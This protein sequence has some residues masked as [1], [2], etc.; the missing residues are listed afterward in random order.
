M[1]DAKN[2][3]SINTAE[4][5]SGLRPILKAL[6]DDLVE[7]A[8]LPGVR[9][10]LRKAYAKEK[11]ASRTADP[12]DL[13]CRWRATQ[14]AASWV[15]SIIFVRTLEDR[16]LIERRRIAGS[17]AEDS[18]QQLRA[19]APFLSDRDY[20]LTVFR[21][22]SRL[23]GVADIFDARH[24]PVWILGPSGQMAGRLL[25]FFREKN[26]DGELR[27]QFGGPDTRFLG[28]LYQDLDEDVRKKFA[29]LQTPDFVESFILD[30]T[31]TPAI[32]TFGLAETKIIDPTCGSGHFLLG[33]FGRLC[34]AWQ[35][36]EPA[37]DKQVLA[38]RALAQVHG[39]DLNPYAVAIARFRLTLA[40]MDAAGIA[41]V[42]KAPPLPLNVCVADSLLHGVT[43]EELRF[44]DQANSGG[45]QAWGDEM[46]ALEDEAEALR[47]LKQRYQAVVGNPPYITEQDRAKRELYRKLYKDSAS[48]KFALGAPFTE[49]FFTL[50]TRGGYAGMI[51][52][53]AFLKRE[54]GKKLIE[55]FLPRVELDLV[56]DTSGAYIPG[57]GTP[58]VLLFGRNQSAGATNIQAVLGSRGEP[59]TPADASKGQVWSSIRDHYNEVGFENDYITVAE[60]ERKRLAKHPWIMAGG[61]AIELMDTLDLRGERPLGDWATSIGFMAITG[62]DD[63]FLRS[64][65]YLAHR[66][67]PTRI[68]GIGEVVRDWSVAEREYLI[69]PYDGESWAP[70]DISKNAG[71]ERELWP[72]KRKL[73]T[74]LMF[75]KTQIQAGFPW[76]EYRH[77]GREKLRT[78]LSIAFAFVA[79]HNH[80]VLDRGGKVFKQTAP[81]IKLPDH[82]TEDDHLALLGYLNSST[83]CFWMKQVCQPKHM[84][85][86]SGANA[87]PFLVRF[88]FD[89]TKLSK[90]PMPTFPPATRQLVLDGAQKVNEMA[91]QLADSHPARLLEQEFDSLSQLQSA[92]AAQSI[93]RSRLLKRMI[94]KQEIIDWIIYA[95]NGLTDLR[96]SRELL[97]G[98]FELALGHRPF[99]VHLARTDEK[100]AQSYGQSH[101]TTP[102]EDIGNHQPMTVRN[103]IGRCIESI[104]DSKSIKLLE[105]P[106]Y[107]RRWIQPQGKAAKDLPTDENLAR[108]AVPAALLN[109]IE[110]S[111]SRVTEPLAPC[112]TR[113]LTTMLAD[114]KRFGIL[115]KLYAGESEPNPQSI[116]SELMDRDSL[117]AT[118]AHTYSD[119]GLKKHVAWVESWELQRREDAGEKVNIQLPPKYTN[120]DFRKPDYYRLRGKLDVPKERFISYPG[121]ESDDDPSPL[122]GWAG[123]DHLQQAEALSTLYQ[124][125]K[126]EDG[127][128]IE[129]LTPML[130]G[131][132]ELVPW[133]K[134][135]H[136]D[137]N[138]QM[139]NARAGEFFE[140]FVQSECATFELTTKDLKAWRPAKS[141]TKRK[142]KAAKPK[143]TPDQLITAISE[144]QT[145]EG[146]PPKAIAKHLGTTAAAVNK[147]AKPLVESG[148]LIETS[149]RPKRY[150]SAEQ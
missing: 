30:Q 40:F 13:W 32:V 132:W 94:W 129:R 23:T 5:L 92:L 6:R 31:L 130:C 126:N 48:G 57:H 26:A 89:G 41:L 105:R 136:N 93:D 72:F 119:T 14:V 125:R 46:F 58:T 33:A 139:G 110:Q 29:L 134:Q 11:S 18:Q 111:L 121:C 43:G 79:T 37:T 75:G 42:A 53:N 104:Q 112:S 36:A 83:A 62:E 28:D 128:A 59:S 78:P 140:A 15:L 39:V 19:L 67:L 60:L 143:I 61:G 118:P 145:D 107:K 54:F 84:G 12:F 123:W 114:Q 8:K 9:D 99:E 25:E 101:G 17:G 85:N 138:P 73:S 133:I 95:A 55:L 127:W 76:W 52:S 148:Q 64:Q 109:C 141:K 113:E 147:L 106:E 56:V 131:L 87:T 82:A 100:L 27:W 51:N 120:K 44:S 142:S 74:R 115:V 1:D 97:M 65:A 96:P 50:A 66:R 35:K 3:T 24:N 49:R 16:G 38:Q 137:P 45:H 80:F 88:E 4:L 63:A 69:F 71:L 149:K 98:D 86:A 68:F 103:W 117:P 70:L 47:I 20:L 146:T 150:R 108:M 116:V 91:A 102:S 144:L 10:G 22:L 90:L 21:E 2:D 135:W 122:I 81:I 124:R 77:V 7:R 34:A